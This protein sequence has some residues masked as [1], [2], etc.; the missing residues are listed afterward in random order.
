M[1]VSFIDLGGGF[2]SPNT[3]KSQYLDGRAGE[4]AVLALRGGDL[5]RAAELDCPAPQLPTLVLETGRALVDDAGSLIT[6]VQATKRLPTGARALVIDAGVN[7]LF[8]AFWYRHDVSPAQEVRGLEDPPCST[9]R[10]A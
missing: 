1:R 5:R 10:C 8:T 7:L 6:T 9:A 3:L 2:A 4:P